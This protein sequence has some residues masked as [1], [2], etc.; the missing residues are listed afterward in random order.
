MKLT[1]GQSR[2]RTGQTRAYQ[3]WRS[4]LKRCLSPNDKQYKNYGGRGISICEEWKVFQNFFADMGHPPTGMSL[5]R[6]DNNSHYRKDNCRWATPKEQANNRRASIRHR[7]S[8]IEI[9][10]E[11][12][13]IREVEKSLGLSQGALWHRLKSGWSIEK[14]CSTPRMSP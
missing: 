10:G 6:R 4:M 3:T 12:R 8:Y 13:A 14:S 11:K 1:H 9:N 2:R 7:I 5:D